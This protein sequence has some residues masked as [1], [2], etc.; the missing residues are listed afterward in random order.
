MS[1]SRLLKRKT[2]VGRI[3]QV[4]A[5]AIYVV[6]SINVSIKAYYINH[7][8]KAQHAESVRNVGDF[9]APALGQAL[10]NF[11][12][13]SIRNLLDNATNIY[14][15]AGCELFNEKQ[16][17]VYQCDTGEEHAAHAAEEHLQEAFNLTADGKAV[18]RLIL[19]YDSEAV[20]DLYYGFLYYEL[21][22]SLALF[23][24]LMAVT[25]WIVN[26]LVRQ[27]I[28]QLIRS[29]QV[30]AGGDLTQTIPVQSDDELGQLARSFN[31]MVDSLNEL[32]LQIQQS[33]ASLTNEVA[34]SASS[35]AHIADST[36]RQETAFNRLRDMFDLSTSMAATANT[37]AQNTLGETEQSR[38]GMANT[39]GAMSEIDSTARQIAVIVSKITGIANQTNL[40]AL[41]AAIEAARAGTQGKG[42]AVVAAE[43]RK[44]AE[45][46][47]EFAKETTRMLKETNSKIADGVQVSQSAGENIA[48]VIGNYAE[49]AE[50]IARI[51][52]TANEQIHL[53]NESV[54][55]IERNLQLTR[56]IIEGH[57]AIEQ[58]ALQLAQAVRKFRT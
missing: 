10:W 33:T 16:E 23:I 15:L 13:Q 56:G 54:D 37:L 7:S 27:P 53:V 43:V 18:G 3:L 46:S 8:F 4:L 28:N 40:L 17:R 35:L 38:Q 25:A 36:E 32:I 34:G 57:N 39:L 58:N 30:I 45:Q 26:R 55:T 52:H 1:L 11:D 20:E 42:F 19:F 9:I 6:L 21:F 41:N 12:E 29:S 14:Q 47:A 49:I 2:L 50:S 51:S 22:L 5:I 31:T 44:L 48:R 24:V